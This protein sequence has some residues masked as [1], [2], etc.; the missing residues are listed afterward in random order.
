MEEQEAVVTGEEEVPT[1]M[2]VQ[3]AVAMATAAQV[4][5]T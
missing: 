4:N 5:S 3:E 1:A 2:E